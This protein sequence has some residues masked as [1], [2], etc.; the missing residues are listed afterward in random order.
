[1]N[2]EQIEKY[3]N[4][5]KTDLDKANKYRHMLV[6]DKLYKY[7]PVDGNGFDDRI[8][9][10]NR[11]ELFLTNYKR[12]NDPYEF[13]GIYITYDDLKKDI[14]DVVKKCM[15]E[16]KYM[17][18]FTSFTTNKYDE[19]LT[20]WAHY[21][22]GHKGFCVEYEIVCKE[23]LWDVFYL[24]N[25]RELKGS[26]IFS[27]PEKVRP[28]MLDN[29]CIKHESW[30]YENEY[31]L[32]FFDEQ[33]NCKSGVISNEDVGLKVSKIIAGCECSVAHK[34]TIKETADILKCE[35]SYLEKSKDEYFLIEKT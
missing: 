19:N 32:I 27:N 5:R 24:K 23:L 21:A 9:T 22:S 4:L 26:L 33:N 3:F 30:S 35:Y 20:M 1:M 18:I 6:P 28:F 12:M 14:K 7:M 31:R 16:M 29:I 2:D 17:V 25:R 8:S 15:D 13:D 11:N 10:L 34:N